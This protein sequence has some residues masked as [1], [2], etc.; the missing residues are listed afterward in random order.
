MKHVIATKYLERPSSLPLSH[1][2]NYPRGCF[3]IYSI[4]ILFVVYLRQMTTYAY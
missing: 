4:F 2:V 1:M 3:V